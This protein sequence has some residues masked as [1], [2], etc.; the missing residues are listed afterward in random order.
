M[1]PVTASMLAIFMAALEEKRPHS[2]AVEGGR[3]GVP[4]LENGS[5]DGLIGI[6]PQSRVE[7]LLSGQTIKHGL[8]RR[9][10][11]SLAS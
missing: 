9:E 6:G 5:L 7:E 10:R 3:G 2:P 4:I 1:N 8:N 11:T